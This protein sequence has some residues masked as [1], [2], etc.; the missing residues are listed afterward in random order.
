M[1]LECKMPNKLQAVDQ[2]ID[3]A[4]EYAR[5]I[6]KQLRQWVHL[7]F[8]DIEEK[9]KWGCPSFE[10]KG[11]VGGMAFFK[12]HVDFRFDKGNMLEDSS[13]LFSGEDNQCVSA[14]QVKSLAAM[15][16]QAVF[17]DY[18]KRAVELNEKGLKRKVEKKP[19]TLPDD[20]IQALS[21]NGKA[22]ACFE[23]FAPG[24]Q[25]D[26]IEWFEQAKREAT[27]QKRI[28]QAIEWLAEGKSRNWKY[29]K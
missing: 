20:F 3:T 16:E 13:E 10:Y 12:Q 19:L 11:I 2:Y 22:K 15:P 7:A 28:S 9:I 26:Y 8:P 17:V 21:K 23:G 18:F 29:Q 4:P 14:I 27:R 5:P 1:S 6:L 24:Y 25:R